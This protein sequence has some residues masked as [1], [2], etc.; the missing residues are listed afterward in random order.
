VAGNISSHD[1]VFYIHGQSVSGQRWNQ[2]ASG[3]T[4]TEVSDPGTNMGT[5]AKVDGHISGGSFV[6]STLY[7]NTATNVIQLTVPVSGTMPAND[8]TS[9]LSAA[10]TSNLVQS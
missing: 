6:T 10:V 2:I 3:V 4:I 1:Q 8:L 5:V 9:I 7:Q